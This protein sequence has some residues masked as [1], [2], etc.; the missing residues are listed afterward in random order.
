M[1][2]QTI[3]LLND[4]QKKELF[5]E[6]STVKKYCVDNLEMYTNYCSMMVNCNDSNSKIVCL[7]FIG[8]GIYHKE[9]LYQS[10]VINPF[11]LY[12]ID[13][14]FSSIEEN[15]VAIINNKPV[16]VNTHFK[17]YFEVRDFKIEKCNDNARDVY[18]VTIISL[19]NIK[20][21]ILIYSILGSKEKEV[22]IV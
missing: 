8:K 22:F 10:I 3:F 21:N 5:K 20:F 19:N 4:T 12:R 14:V 16:V 6:I 7:D 9:G 11:K 13:N 17:Y 1:N 18:K 2:D 15:K